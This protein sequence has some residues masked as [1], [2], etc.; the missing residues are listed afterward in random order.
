MAKASIMAAP[1]ATQ[2][3][4]AK[5]RAPLSVL[6]ALALAAAVLEP[7]AS[8]E[9]EVDLADEESVDLPEAEPVPEAVAVAAAPDEEPVAEAEVEPVMVIGMAV[10]GVV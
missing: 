9:P 7:E 1:P 8:E 3:P 4:V 10:R 2:L 6:L 5:G